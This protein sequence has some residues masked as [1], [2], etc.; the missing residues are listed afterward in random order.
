MSAKIVRVSAVGMF[1]YR[2]EMSSDA[3]VKWGSTGVSFS[4]CIR[5]LELFMLNALGKGGEVACF[6]C[7]QFG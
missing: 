2:L 7:E 4:L 5:S 1:V 6:L 3:R